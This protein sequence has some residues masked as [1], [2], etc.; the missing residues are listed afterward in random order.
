MTCVSSCAFSISFS[1]QTNMAMQWYLGKV[2]ACC[3]N[4]E[5]TAAQSRFIVEVCDDFWVNVQAKNPYIPFP[6]CSWRKVMA[7][8]NVCV[9]LW[10]YEACISIQY[11]SKTFKRSRV[12]LLY[13]IPC[14]RSLLRATHTRA[15]A[16]LPHHHW[17][18]LSERKITFHL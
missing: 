12:A 9:R 8:T 15:R 13:K 1:F 10:L 11:S 14:V 7:N 5:E 4:E 2:K 6:C 17:N 16:Q 18:H 3:A